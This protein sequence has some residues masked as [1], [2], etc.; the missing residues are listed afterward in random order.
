MRKN[1]KHKVAI[2]V[3]AVCFC[4]AAM[5]ALYFLNLYNAANPSPSPNKPREAIDD[6]DSEFPEV[7]WEYW[8]GV[9]PDIVG[10]ITVPGTDINH[11]V[12]QAPTDNPDYYLKHD[13][14]K[15]YNPMGCLYLDADCKE[16]GLA[17]RNAV[18]LGH[19]WEGIDS[20]AA[21]GFSVIADYK[22]YD[23]AKEHATVL[24]QTP[25]SQMKY[26]VRLVDIVPGWQPTKRCTF[27]DD[28]DYSQW[29]EECL[30]SAETTLDSETRPNQTISLVSCSYNYWRQNERTVVITSQDTETQALSKT[31][32]LESQK[33][34]E[35]KE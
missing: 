21:G 29:Y 24:I 32:T 26:Q 19:H 17:T 27:E 20:I 30:E 15:N 7:D 11:P 25:N 35:K 6:T 12:V 14:Y 23:F 10:W 1:T 31:K 22:D 28:S 18:I 5:L 33:A 9:N 34:V 8:L 3:A 4:T 2:S 13:I 16:L